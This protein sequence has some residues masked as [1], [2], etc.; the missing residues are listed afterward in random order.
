MLETSDAEQ[1]FME[2]AKRKTPKKLKAVPNS[3]LRS[4]ALHRYTGRGNAF[5]N[6]KTGFRPDID[7]V[8]RSGWE[9]NVMRVLKSFSIPF[10][11]EPQVFYF[12]IK[13]GT[14][15]YTPDIYLTGTGEWIEVKGF[16]DD[17]SRVKIKRFKK[18]FP[19]EFATLTMIIGKAKKSIQI[20]E[21]L[22]VPTVVYYE[23][24]SRLFRE[25]IINWE[26]R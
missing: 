18:Y 10:E 3:V 17:A 15:A 11:F 1:F 23:D 26:G 21:E 20:C 19:E 2:R 22:E 4:A 24:V 5:R 12:P 8:C 16:F 6:T 14:R 9:A 25:K 7:I 13:R